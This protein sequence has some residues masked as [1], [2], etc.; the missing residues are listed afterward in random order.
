MKPFGPIDGF[1]LREWF[2]APDSC[3]LTQCW[4]NSTIK[5]TSEFQLSTVFR[6]SV[7]ENMQDI[8]IEDL[9][10]MIQQGVTVYFHSRR[11]IVDDPKKRGRKTEVQELEYTPEPIYCDLK[12]AIAQLAEPEEPDCPYVKTQEKNLENKSPR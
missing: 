8:T 7:R 10:N 9:V 3:A 11:V 12:D 6:E 1:A 2:T 5:E 4:I